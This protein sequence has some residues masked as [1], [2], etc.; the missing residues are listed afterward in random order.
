MTKPIASIL[1]LVTAL[2]LAPSTSAGAGSS[3]T[4]FGSGAGHGI[5]LSQYGALGL[6]QAGWG[7]EKIVKHY[8]RNVNVT[9]RTPPAPNIKVGLLQ[10]RSAVQLKAAT[11]SF[12][13][14]LKDGTHVD[15]V[16]QG[17]SRTVTVV[18]GEY[19]VKKGNG[20][21]VGGRWGGT[22]NHLFAV[23][24]GGRIG[25]PDW[26]HQVGRGKLQFDIVSGS[27]AHLLA[28]LKIEEYVYGVSEVSSSW[29]KMALRAQAILARSYGYWR[30]SGAK[31]SGCSCDVFPTSV[32]QSY[33]GWTK[34]SESM[35]NRWVTAVQKTRKK[36]IT[37]KGEY[38]YTPYTSS[39][40]GHT[41]D[42]EKVW[43][44]SPPAGHLKGVCDPRDDV[45]ANPNTT[46]SVNFSA[47]TVTNA[48]GLGIGTVQKFTD[49]KR[50][51]SGRV[52]SVKVV[53]TGGSAVVSGWTVRSRLGL[54]DTRFSVNQNLNITGKIRAEYDREDCAPGRATGERKGIDGG[55]YQGFKKGRIY[56][57]DPADVVVWIRGAVLK[58]YL[59]V[60]GHGGNLGLPRKYVKTQ[61]GTK[62]VF[63]GGTI[64][65]VSGCSVNYA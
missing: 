61:D 52:T 50:G 38:V 32:D 17:Q 57:N 16:A 35:G 39:S 27:Q 28:V 33:V 34:E 12:E 64:V 40:G 20:T 31:R 42:I 6:A 51:E 36:V 23:R 58:K 2:V 7:A 29:P 48:L 18:D 49:Y 55:A 22:N 30:V 1:A 62:G 44:G 8:F 5:G 24:N 46:W 26:G 3:F 25:I 41:E 54:K 60:G 56:A 37:F 11:G 59:D 45:G 21:F 63:D 13:L 43:S 53:G 47:G 15:S 9:K 4:F 19:R 10:Y 14:K 65:C